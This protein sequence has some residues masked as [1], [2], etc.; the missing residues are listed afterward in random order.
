MGVNLH[1]HIYFIG[2]KSKISHETILV[3]NT[4]ITV[5]INLNNLFFGRETITHRQ[6]QGAQSE[7]KSGQTQREVQ[8][9]KNQ[10]FIVTDPIIGKTR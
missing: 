2:V 7:H 3:S 8:Q 5:S 6:P 10:A 4:Q 9:G 1:T